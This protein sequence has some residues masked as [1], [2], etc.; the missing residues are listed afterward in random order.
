MTTVQK[1][2]AFRNVLANMSMVGTPTPPTLVHVKINNARNVLGH[3]LFAY[4]RQLGVSKPEWVPEYNEVAEWLTDNKG[5][6]LLLHG[7]CGRGKS[8]LTRYVLPAILNQFCGKVVDVYDIQRMNEELDKAILSKLIAIDD[9]GTEEI[10]VKY[11]ERR[12]A[13]AEIIDMAEKKGN[14]VIISTNL[15]GKEIKE[16]YGD[17]VFDRVMAVTTRVPFSGTSFR[18]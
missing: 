14:L 13:F 9:I 6:G 1:S 18:K 8:V 2:N 15:S 4:L 5:R 10:R 11:G 16:R 7:T 17:R 12:M 3:Y